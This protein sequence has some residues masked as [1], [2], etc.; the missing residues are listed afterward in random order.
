MAFLELQN[1]TKHFGATKAVT[2]VGFSL[3]RGQV[4]A[5]VGENGAGK[6]TIVKMLTGIYTPDAGQIL[7]DGKPQT[8]SSPQQAWRAGISAIH[9]ETVMFDEL[10]VAENIF[11]G[12]QPSRFGLVQWQTLLLQTQKVLKQIDAKIS[13]QSLLKTL[14]VAQ[15]HLVQIARALCQDSSVVIMD[16]PTAALSKAEIEDFFRVVAQ[17]KK[18]Q[19]AIILVTHKFDEIFSHADTYAVLRDGELVGTGEIAQTSSEALVRLM[20]GRE[21]GQLFPKQ[22]VVPQEVVL[23]VKDFSHPT[24][25]AG[26]NFSLRRGEILGFYGLIGAGRSEV[27]QAIFGLNPQKT[28]QLEVMGKPAQIDSPA[29]AVRLGVVYVPEDRQHQGAILDM[30]I[31]QNTTLPSLAGLGWWLNRQK[32]TALTMPLAEKLELRAAHLEQNVGELSGG[33]QQKV[34]LSKWLATNPKVLILDEPTKGIDVGAK[35]AVHTLMSQMVAD[36]LAVILVSSELPEVLHMSDRIVVMRQGRVVAELEANAT[37][38]ETVVAFA[39]G[40]EL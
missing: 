35:S 36:G 15:K 1:L 37:T 31:V 2:G 10:S 18:E 30:S 32:E 19:K 34:V 3:E 9:Q 12:N 7:L 8:F 28:G 13:P 27:M 4:L 24:E 6:S 22:A 20:A 29:D 23:T 21:V 39:A 11:M 40:V 5:L 26:I 33:N 38:A 17:L 16:E 25:F 14:S